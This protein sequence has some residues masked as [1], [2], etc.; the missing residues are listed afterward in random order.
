[1]LKELKQIRD[2]LP[3]YAKLLIIILFMNYTRGRKGIIWRL[4][5]TAMVLNDISRIRS[6]LRSEDDIQM[7][8]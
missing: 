5:T 7:L 4:K 8:L 1:M 2:S 6:I 3:W